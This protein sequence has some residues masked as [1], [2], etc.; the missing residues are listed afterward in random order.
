MIVKKSLKYRKFTFFL[1][2]CHGGIHDKRLYV[3]DFQ[4]L[5]VPLSQHVVGHNLIFYLFQTIIS[6][7]NSALINLVAMDAEWDEKPRQ[8]KERPCSAPT[9]QGELKTSLLSAGEVNDMK[10]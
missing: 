7:R 8:Q 5:A 9:T 1:S 10:I 3:T 2:F 4:D 6:T